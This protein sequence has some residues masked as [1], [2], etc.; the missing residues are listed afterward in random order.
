MRAGH[1]VQRGTFADLV[2]RPADPFVT[3]FIRAQ[4]PLD[5]A[6]MGIG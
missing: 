2:G 5:A 3:E 4:R 6:S 1:I